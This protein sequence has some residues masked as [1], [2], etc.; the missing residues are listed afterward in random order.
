MYNTNCLIEDIV[1]NILRDAVNEDGVQ[2]LTK[3][4]TIARLQ[5]LRKMVISEHI[6]GNTPDDV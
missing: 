3:E 4:R 2:S 5:R 6:A 1:E